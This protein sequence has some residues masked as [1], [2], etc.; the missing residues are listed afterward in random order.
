VCY[1]FKIEE[2]RADSKGRKYW[3][4]VKEGGS[5]EYFYV[6]DAT[7]KMLIDPLNAE[8]LLA[9]DY[10][11]ING[12][13]FQRRT[14]HTEWFLRPGDY[15]YLLGTVKK[16]RDAALQRRDTLNERLRALKADTARLTAFDTNKDGQISAEEWD[17]AR[18][19]T[20]QALLEEELRRPPDDTDDLVIAKGTGE[21]TF[22]IADRDE[23]DV[24]GNFMMKS[25]F[26]SIGGIALTLLMFASM[27]A[28]LGIL[29]RVPPIPWEAFY[30]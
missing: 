14:R 3:A 23:R 6:E 15:V 8:L 12:S 9:Q 29:S 22:V 21:Q 10:Q 1:R 19:Q 18:R 26:S 4:T 11:Q 27:L 7:G 24:A 30:R 13:L 2:E 5:A 28:R 20:E 25:A 16:F 17:A